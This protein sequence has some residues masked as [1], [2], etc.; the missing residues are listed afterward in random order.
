MPTLESY[1]IELSDFIKEKKTQGTINVHFFSKKER[2]K[3]ALKFS[4]MTFCA[5]VFSVFIPLLHFVLVPGLLI[6]SVF[7]Y[8]FIINKERIIIEGSGS[9]PEC[10]KDF[11]LLSHSFSD[12]LKQSC[13][14]CLKHISITLQLDQDLVSNKK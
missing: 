2:L 12:H 1:S 10:K 14:S 11:T 5:A 8:F 3:R 9:C 6:A 4:G 7:V 13:P